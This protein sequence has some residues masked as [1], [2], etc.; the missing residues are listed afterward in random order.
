M[1]MMVNETMTVEEWILNELWGRGLRVGETDQALAFAKRKLDTRGFQDNAGYVN[2]SGR[3]VKIKDCWN[4]PFHEYTQEGLDDLY[5]LI[6]H[7]TFTWLVNQLR[8]RS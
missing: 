3:M 8:S 1:G 6:E 2:K 7:H 4:T 5:H